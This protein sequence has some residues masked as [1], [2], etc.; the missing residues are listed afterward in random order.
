MNRL[1]QFI[2][3]AISMVYLAQVQAAVNI[4]TGIHECKALAAEESDDGKAKTPDK[5]KD[6]EEEEEEEPDCE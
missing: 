1:T 4:N 3:I 6:G 2:L 5:K